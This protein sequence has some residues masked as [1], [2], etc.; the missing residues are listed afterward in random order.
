VR[1]AGLSGEE[2]IMAAFIENTK[3]AARIG[4]G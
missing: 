1:E 3:D 2:A 4:G